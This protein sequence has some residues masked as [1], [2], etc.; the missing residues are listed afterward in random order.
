MSGF[1]SGYKNTVPQTAAD[2]DF[3]SISFIARQILSGA[4]FATLV[5]VKSVTNSGE[6]SPVG[7]VDVKPMVNMLDGYGKAIE[8]GTVY[9]LPYMRLQGGTSA[10]ILD[11]QVGDIGIAIFAQNDISS[12][13][14]T[15]TVSNPGSGRRNSMSDGLYIGGVLNGTP[16]QYL[17]FLAGE[18]KITSDTKI[19]VT[20]PIVAV[21]ASTSATV[22]SPVSSIVSATSA[23][24]T[25]PI[26][27]ITAATSATVTSPIVTVIAATSATIIAPI[28][29]LA[30]VGQTL[31][32]F[33][34]SA[35][36]D[37]FNNHVHPD[38]VSGNT[39]TPNS[40]ITDSE[41]TTTVKGA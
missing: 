40:T 24:I 16:T 15:K 8:H 38:P 28:I 6:I 9:N 27:A 25:S 2:N 34:T 32:K 7:F 39:G 30:G 1:E 11:P 10:I 5:Q 20:A 12:V 26:I 21:N 3:N 18:L 37:V 33:I 19:T 41:M 17:R 22:T 14:K 29:N 31:V 35:F 13:K 23:T 36:Q 4:N